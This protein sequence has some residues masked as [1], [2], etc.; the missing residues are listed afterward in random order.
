M[1]QIFVKALQPARSN[2][3]DYMPQRRSQ[4]TY[5]R[6]GKRVMGYSIST[7]VLDCLERRT[8]EIR[9]TVVEYCSIS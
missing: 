5:S 2:R 7:M 4:A 8:N 9:R 6:E 3:R 1:L